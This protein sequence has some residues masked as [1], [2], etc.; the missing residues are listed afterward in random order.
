MQSWEGDAWDMGK[1]GRAHVGGG[2][3]G[4]GTGGGGGGDWGHV[5]H[6][7]RGEVGHV[8]HG[9]GIVGRVHKTQMLVVQWRTTHD[10]YDPVD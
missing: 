3:G 1:G 10:S 5:G 6:G 4:G 7:G 2:G 9:G 8:G